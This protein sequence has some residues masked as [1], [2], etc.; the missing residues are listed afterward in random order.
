MLD[1]TSTL[2]DKAKRNILTHIEA[3][4]YLKEEGFHPNSPNGD[5]VL[6]SAAAAVTSRSSLLIHGEHGV[7]KR[8]LA[9]LVHR[10]GVDGENQLVFISASDLTPHKIDQRLKLRGTLV[11]IDVD[12]IETEVQDALIDCLSENPAESLARII[13]T[14][15]FDLKKLVESGRI[16]PDLCDKL[17]SI[18]VELPPLRE[19]PGDIAE[20]AKFFLSRFRDA[21]RSLIGESLSDSAIKKLRDY[22]WP[23]NLRQLQTV[24]RYA[25]ATCPDKL[26]DHQHI[27]FSDHPL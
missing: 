17:S 7:G 24:I 6:Q 3:I 22:A 10:L 2:P 8:R 14:T 23:G 9:R 25:L 13:S 20:I 21:Q 27:D 16:R 4:K 15:S 12:E 18:V 19:R 1:N 5:Q 11:I 26:I